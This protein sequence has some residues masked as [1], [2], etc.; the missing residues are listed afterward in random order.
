MEKTHFELP[1][2]NGG[3]AKIDVEDVPRVQGRAWHISR[4]GYVVSRVAGK[5]VRLHRHLMGDLVAGVEC[6]HINGDPLDNRRCNLRPATRGQNRSNTRKERGC[7]SQYK[8]VTLDRRRAGKWR[9]QINNLD[10]NT[11]RQK[12][13]HLGTYDLPIYAAL[14]YDAEARKRYGEY[15]KCNFPPPAHGLVELCDGVYLQVW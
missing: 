4:G 7:L 12:N 8:G 6:D 1:L 2:S 14:A 10:P 11:G 3:Y 13:T 5:G 9:A 15:A